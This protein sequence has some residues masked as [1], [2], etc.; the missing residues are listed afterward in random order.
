M[1]IARHRTAQM[2]ESQKPSFYVKFALPSGYLHKNNRRAVP[3]GVPRS[4]I[5]AETAFAAKRKSW[6]G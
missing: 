2:L 3:T 5:I 4:A 6:K 1:F